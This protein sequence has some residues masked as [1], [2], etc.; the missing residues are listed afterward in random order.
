MVTPLL[1]A[2]HKALR[3]AA[4]EDAAAASR[5]FVPSAVKV[6]G[7]RMPI[8]NHLARKHKAGGLA[9]SKALWRSGAFEE[10]LLAAKLLGSVARQDPG[11]VLALVEEFSG[12]IEDWAVCDT[13]GMQSV[14][15]I[16]AKQQARI[17][18]LSRRLIAAQAMWQRR[19]GVVLLT[20]YAKDA[21]LR[22]ELVAIALPLRADK[23]RYVQKALAWL[24]R[25][26]AGRPASAHPR[27][28]SSRT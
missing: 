21:R 10:R 24:D 6:Y 22:E 5:K 23:E 26:I 11:Q 4:T 27:P 13:M 25:D 8:I 2:I 20:H 16:A 9:L 12:E 19:L 1:P 28:G 3:D 14:K 7:V 17:L 15:T 18:E